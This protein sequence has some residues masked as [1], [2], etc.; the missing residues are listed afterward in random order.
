M[1]F[2][3]ASDD[4]E[5]Q[6]LDVVLARRAKVTRARAQRSIR[7]GLVTVAGA[8]ARPG[9]RLRAGDEVA[10][11]LAPPIVAAPGPEDIPLVRR[12]EDER[13]LVVSKPAGLVTHPAAGHA[14]GTLVNAL[15]ALGV[16]LAA[17][18]SV[19]P[20]IVHRLDK[21]TSGLLLV[22]KDDEAQAF[23]VT[24]LRARQIERRYL[25]LVKGVPAPASGTVQAPVGRHP[26]RRTAMAVVPGG[27][28]AVTHYR[29]VEAGGDCALLELALETGRTHQIRVHLA[30]IGHP[31]LGDRTYGGQTELAIELGLARPFLH[32]HRLSFP[33]PDG[34]GRVEVADELPADLAQV[35]GRAGLAQPTG[36]PT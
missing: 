8:R 32:A 34:S 10:G 29:V 1:I 7:A 19:R 21:G 3:V 6:R 24:A 18:A 16:P 35:L 22:A 36:R 4:D 14:S 31:V 13:V 9:D 12:Y 5:G 11:E 20:G 23:L 28:P 27:R 17:R 30:H 33:H 2:F 25:C 15:L 26:R